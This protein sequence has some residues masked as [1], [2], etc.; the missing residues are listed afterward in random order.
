MVNKTNRDLEI[1]LCLL[2]KEIS[3]RAINEVMNGEFDN[4]SYTLQILIQEA[5][6][7]DSYLGGET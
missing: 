3:Q 7:V 5:K 1:Q 2:L 4:A 6:L